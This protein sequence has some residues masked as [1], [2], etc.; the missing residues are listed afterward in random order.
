[1]SSLPTPIDVRTVRMMRE[2]SPHRI[3]VD[4]GTGMLNRPTATSGGGRLLTL[5]TLWDYFLDMVPDPDSALAQNPE[6]DEVIRQQP[7]VHACMRIRELTV[8]SLPARI[9]PSIAKSIDKN[10][11]QI[12]ADYTNDVLE[13]LP[14][15]VELYRQM[16]RA[17]LYGGH[18]H[19]F[20]WAKVD[21]ANRPVQFFPVDKS[22][23]VFD[24]LGNLAILT[25]ETPVWGSLVAPDPNRPYA[26]L[27]KDGPNGESIWPTPP[28][29]F[30]YHKYMAEGGPWYRPASEGYIYWGRGENTHLFIPVSFDQFVLRFRMKWLERHGMPL[31]ILYYNDADGVSTE[32]QR[33]VNSIRGEGV[34]LIPR[35]PGTGMEKDYYTVEWQEPPG[36]G[37]EAFSRFQEEW[38]T[39]RIEKILLGGA[40]LLS[41]G[42]N[43]S[44]G[45]T[46]DQRDAGARIVFRY[47]AINI[48]DTITRQLIPHIVQ[49]K[50]PGLPQSY[51]PRHVLAPEEIE[52]QETRLSVLSQAAQLVPVRE[53]D[54]YAAANITR[55]KKTLDRKTGQMI[56][57][58]CVFT[59]GN[60]GGGAEDMLSGLPGMGGG[61][62]PPGAAAP[63]PPTPPGV[64]TSR[65]GQ[66]GRNKRPPQGI[67]GTGKDMKPQ[68]G[69]P[70]S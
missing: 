41:V 1:M 36:T 23:F 44:Y 29:K 14:N 53:D 39:P 25:R 7:D 24:R 5:E 51:F 46:V 50:W 59:G 15:R 19:E 17:V 21:G 22:R 4:S 64:A 32:V 20:L 37:V 16:Q 18:G 26:A 13:D 54:I 38:V 60:Q 30:I 45:A 61:Q 69:I 12:V 52:D 6:F 8:A 35:P 57:E 48:D 34:V 49:A 9:M 65:T 43:G 67:I 33:I 47:D 70:R 40:N 11:A 31:A 55:P 3:P 28:G 62:K 66:I 27:K 56:E 68:H 42:D 2:G 58:P 63:T 10:F